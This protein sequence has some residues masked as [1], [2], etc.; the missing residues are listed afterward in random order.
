M[1]Q[2]VGYW[3]R[4]TRSTIWQK[5]KRWKTQYNKITDEKGDI[6]TN[7]NEIHLDSLITCNEIETEIESPYKEEPRTWWIHGQ[8]LPNL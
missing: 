2:Q 7:T 1:K 3:K 5:W 6:T 8:I 4:L